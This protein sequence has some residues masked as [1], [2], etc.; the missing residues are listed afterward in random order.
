MVISYSMIN[1]S[2]ACHR[3]YFN[4]I[5]ERFGL[6]D[7]KYM[8]VYMCV[9]VCIQACEQ[10][11]TEVTSLADDLSI[12]YFTF[13]KHSF[14]TRTIEYRQP[15][16]QH[17]WAA[18]LLE[19]KPYLPPHFQTLHS[20]DSVELIGG[21]CWQRRGGGFFLRFSTVYVRAGVCARARENTVDNYDIDTSDANCKAEKF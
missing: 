7:G 4:D 13:L 16:I 14:W 2:I 18:N 11:R 17:M 5:C 20:H 3:W 8:C 1:R 21:M 19:A 10:V 15:L 6:H 9:Y 12:N